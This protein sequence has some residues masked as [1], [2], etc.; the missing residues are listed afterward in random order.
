MQNIIQITYCTQCNWL[1]RSSWMG[2]ELLITFKDE[3]DT[4][5]LKPGK[6][7]IF[8]IY[9]NKK[10]IWCRKENK[11]FPEITVLKKLVRDVIAPDKNLGHIDRKKN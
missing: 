7:G 8:Q 4:L 9:A 5:S 3:I 10:L 1:L 6:G 11:G 2:Q